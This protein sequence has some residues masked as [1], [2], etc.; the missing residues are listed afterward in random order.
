MCPT[1]VKNGGAASQT[2]VLAVN[3]GSVEG[4]LP[5]SLLVD[6]RHGDQSLWIELGVVESSESVLG[7]K[8]YI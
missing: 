3:A 2:R 5:E 7:Y 1:S 4:C 8:L 6:I